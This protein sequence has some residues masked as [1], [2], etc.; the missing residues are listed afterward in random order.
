MRLDM[1]HITALITCVVCLALSVP[2]LVRYARWALTNY[3]FFCAVFSLFGVSPTV[4]LI[5]LHQQFDFSLLAGLQIVGASLVMNV[6][7]MGAAYLFSYEGDPVS[8]RS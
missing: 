4:S 8:E 6:F 5:R 1:F 2:L 7:A 3:V